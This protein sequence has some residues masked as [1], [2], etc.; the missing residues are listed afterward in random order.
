MAAPVPYLDL[1]AARQELGGELEQ[2]V[3]RVLD[4]G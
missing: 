1:D 3:T 4:S 2:A